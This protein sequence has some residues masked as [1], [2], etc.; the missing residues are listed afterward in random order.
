MAES[1][2]YYV[3][4]QNKI[5]LKHKHLQGLSSKHIYSSACLPLGCIVL[6]TLGLYPFF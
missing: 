1:Q 5:V 4:Y 3:S 2:Q 6:F